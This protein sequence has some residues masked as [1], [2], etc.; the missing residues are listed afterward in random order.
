MEPLEVRHSSLSQQTIPVEAVTTVLEILSDAPKQAQTVALESQT[1]LLPTLF[2]AI[3]VP[4]VISRIADGAILYANEHYCSTF[5]L[6]IDQMC[7]RES[8]AVAT[9]I[10]SALP[11]PAERSCSQTKH[12]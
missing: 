8:V 4:L 6:A 3:P 12:S 1:Q 11:P 10:E 7:D 2:K 5:G 9:F